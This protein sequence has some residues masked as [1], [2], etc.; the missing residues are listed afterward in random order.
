MNS[1]TAEHAVTKHVFGATATVRP[2]LPDLSQ[3]GS[4]LVRAIRQVLAAT[5][6]AM[7]VAYED[8]RTMAFDEWKATLPPV[9]AL[10]RFQDRVMK[11]GILLTM[12]PLLVAS[13]VD[14]FY[15][16][17]G[18]VDP[19]R[20]EMGPTD[21]LLFERLSG[22][23]GEGLVAA[24]ADVG[25]LSATVAAC[26]FAASDAALGGDESAVAVQR[27]ATRLGPVEIGAIEIVYPLAAIRALGNFDGARGAAA[28]IEPDPVWQR[29]LNDAVMQ[30][31]LPVRTVL[32]RPSLGLP[33][34]M[35]LAPGDF[36]PVTL[37]ARVPVT[38]GGRLLA[39]GTIGEANGRAAIKIDRIEHGVTFDA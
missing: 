10:A 5:G 21:L 39:H 29:S 26:S 13:L 20:V 1:A 8:A 38:V 30:T 2:A 18:T 36:I 33:Q 9:V 3:V 31:R 28:P 12:P 6:A 7:D 15:G 17:T 16:G 32:A 25:H 11:P 27:F 23:V 19:A 35:A 34:L 14:C 4:R 24:W 22:G 37:P